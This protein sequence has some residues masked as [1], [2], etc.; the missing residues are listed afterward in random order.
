[1]CIYSQYKMIFSELSVSENSSVNQQ[2]CRQFLPYV[3]SHLYRRISFCEDKISAFL[4]LLMCQNQ[5]RHNSMHLSKNIV[6][7]YWT[8]INAKANVSY[9]ALH[10]QTARQAVRAARQQGEARKIL[11][12]P[13]FPH[14][15]SFKPFSRRFLRV[16]QQLA[17]QKEKPTCK[18]QAALCTHPS[19]PP[20]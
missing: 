3:G 20:P 4:A 16:N 9:T 10:T 17:Q 13:F 15:A 7:F 6:C 11:K 14:K 2:G 5:D 1:M 19:L 8:I 18:I 12:I